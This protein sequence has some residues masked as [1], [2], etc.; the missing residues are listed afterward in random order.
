MFLTLIVRAAV[1][2]VMAM[3]TPVEMACASLA[4]WA[5]EIRE[6]KKAVV[7]LK[8]YVTERELAQIEKYP[9][10]VIAYRQAQLIEAAELAYQQ[11]HP[12]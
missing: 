2:L 11:K 9:D 10:V 12:T 1:G 7:T 3:E 5:G 8:I 4:L 6:E